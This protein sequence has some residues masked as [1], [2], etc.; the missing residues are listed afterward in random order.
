M[1]TL[2][3]VR[4]PRIFLVV[5]VII[6]IHF[7]LSYFAGHYVAKEIGTEM[8][9]IVAEGS[10]EYYHS[11][12]EEVFK[13]MKQNANKVVNNWTPIYSVM[14]FPTTPLINPLKE[15]AYRKFLFAPALAGNI[16]REEFKARGAIN[17]NFWAGINSMAFGLLIYVLIKLCHSYRLK[18][19][20]KT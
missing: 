6:V 4:I 12:D 18:L 8:G 7:T 9:T 14:N 19:L 11:S 16:S 20:P 13:E 1:Q 2:N 15:W 17:D 10:S 3:K 5:L